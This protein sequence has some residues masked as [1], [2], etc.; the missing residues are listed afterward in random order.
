MSRILN[1]RN[2]VLGWF[3]WRAAKHAARKRAR[4]HRT[5]LRF[6]GAGSI[7]A[8]IVGVVVVGTHR[9]PSGR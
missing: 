1:R 8:L 5:T 3:A 6:T 4:R 7:A 2:A 9:V